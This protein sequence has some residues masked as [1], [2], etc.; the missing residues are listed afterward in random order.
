MTR[1]EAK[2]A[3]LDPDGVLRIGGRVCVPKVGDLIR[4]ILKEAHCTRYSI[5]PG[6]AKMYHDL[7]QHYWWYGMK[8]DISEFVAKCLTC[9]QVKC[10]HQRPGGEFQ[11]M[12][13]PTWK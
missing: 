2:E 1:G 9:Q 10:E 7:S 8:K 4:L 11:R 5:H 13:I 3:V 6:V 12:P